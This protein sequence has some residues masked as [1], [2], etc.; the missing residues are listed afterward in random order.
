MYV[1]AQLSS[2]VAVFSRQRV[3]TRCH[4][5][6]S[7][8]AVF[9]DL[10]DVT[11]TRPGGDAINVA[12]T[13]ITDPTCS[14]STVLNTDTIDVDGATGTESV[15]IDI[16]GGAYA[17]GMTDEPGT[18]DEIEWSIDP[19]GELAIEG[20]AVADTIRLGSSGINLS[21]DGDAD[22]V[23][24]TPIALVT[25][26]AGAGNDVVT[27]VGA[28]GADPGWWMS[29]I[30]M[31]GE[32]GADKLTGG[33]A[34]DEIDGG[35]EKDTLSAFKILD[36]EDVFVGGLGIDTVSYSNRTA[37]LSLTLDDAAND[38]AAGE[39]DNL[40]EIENVI[41]GKNNDN[42]DGGPL[43]MKNTFRGGTGN[44]DLFGGP[45][46]DSLQGDGGADD[47]FG[48]AGKDTL[49]SLDGVNGN[50]T[51]DGGTESDTCKRDAGDSVLNCEA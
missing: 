33:L 34:D 5:A 20:S 12:A 17:P 43:T 24:A 46:A 32:A 18:T 15:T 41:G 47:L 3:G 14:G 2:A 50:D 23:P 45:G 38:G 4:R 26:N 21:N 8:L 44:D 35:S 37:A 25:V 30:H 51:L 1:A 39:G 16:S 40:L 29:P 9:A 6:G 22:V 27:G 28:F 31:N 13:S 36:G 49:N 42:I 10:E 19:I 7:M 11:F 48:E